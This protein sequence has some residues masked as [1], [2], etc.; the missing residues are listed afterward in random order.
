MNNLNGKIE[1][2]EQ[3]L[4]IL[5]QDQAQIEQIKTELAEIKQQAAS[6]KGYARWRAEVGERYY[7]ITLRVHNVEESRSE[8]DQGLWDSGNYFRTAERAQVELEKRFAL[9]RVNDA[10]DYENSHHQTLGVFLGLYYGEHGLTYTPVSQNHFFAD[11]INLIGSE[12]SAKRIIQKYE[13]DLKLI[14]GVNDVQ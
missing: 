6:K 4:Q 8:S 3:Q 13:A 5:Q 14:M 7:M 11:P 10:I 9:N 1:R 2:L 12:S